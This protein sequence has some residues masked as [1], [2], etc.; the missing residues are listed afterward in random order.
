[1]LRKMAPGL[2]D[3]EILQCFKK[4]DIN[5]DNSI[6]FREFYKLLAYGIKGSME[7]TE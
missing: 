6:S 2:K 5:E 7:H 1:M 4:F 3:Y